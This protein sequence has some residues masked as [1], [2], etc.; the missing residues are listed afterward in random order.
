MVTDLVEAIFRHLPGWRF[1]RPDERDEFARTMLGVELLVR[2]A[3]GAEIVVTPQGSVNVEFAAH[4]WRRHNG[5]LP[6]P[7]SLPVTH[8]VFERQDLAGNAEKIEQAARLIAL[9]LV[10]LCDQYRRAAA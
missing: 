8:L 7:L 5:T 10:P 2:E 3:D 4:E 6:V 1:A 9:V